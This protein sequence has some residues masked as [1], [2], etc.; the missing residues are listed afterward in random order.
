MVDVWLPDKAVSRYVVIACFRVLDREWNDI[1]ER[2]KEDYFALQRVATAACVI[3]AGYFGGLQGE[4][5]NK[6]DLTVMRKHWQGATQH[7]QHPHVPLML[8]GKFKKQKGL[9]LSVNP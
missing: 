5:I 8:S 3:I 9:K 2:D 7:V 1:R 6:V 4:E